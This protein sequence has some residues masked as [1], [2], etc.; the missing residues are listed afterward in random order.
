MTI[1][2]AKNLS[3]KFPVYANH[4]R[5]LKKSMIKYISAGKIFNQEKKIYVQAL[6]NINFKINNGDKVGLIGSN[7]SGKTTL[8]R[9]MMGIYHPSEGSIM[10]K[11]KVTSLIDI[12][13]GI[14][15]DATGYENII[16]R[17]LMLNVS[18]KKIEDKINEI[19]K[20]SELGHYLSLP[21]RTYSSG[22]KIRLAFSI[23]VSIKPK[24]ILMDEWLSV[25][26]SEFR[27]KASLKINEIIEDSFAFIIAS[28]DFVQIKKTCN[29]IF[30]M[31]QG[32]LT[33]L[34]TNDL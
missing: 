6:K 32:I 20:F 27:E 8:L 33:E 10:C 9:A 29:R 18:R 16:L 3:I 13:L 7:G 34:S 1:I 25:G 2:E 17:G 21:V 23:I 12:E 28:H 14:D 30:K 15:E 24:V 5:S 22:M 4:L 19:E 31:E 26:D 11:E